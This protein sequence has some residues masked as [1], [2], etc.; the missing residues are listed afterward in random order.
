MDSQRTSGYASEWENV[1]ASI[2]FPNIA[3]PTLEIFSV[4]MLN[5]N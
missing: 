1:D 3:I 2:Y 5:I 4:I